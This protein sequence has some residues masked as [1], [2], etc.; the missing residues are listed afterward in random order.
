MCEFLPQCVSPEY[1]IF[2]MQTLV[3]MYIRKVFLPW[4]KKCFPDRLSRLQ[5]STADKKKICGRAPTQRP[6]RGDREGRPHFR[7]YEYFENLWWYVFAPWKFFLI[8][9]D[10]FYTVKYQNLQEFK[11][12]YKGQKSITKGFF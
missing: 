6:S 8:L 9:C 7:R 11:R 12:I 2:E 3:Y 5:R 10:S 1:S 4:Q